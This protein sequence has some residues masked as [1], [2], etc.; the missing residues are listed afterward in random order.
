[1]TPQTEVGYV[2]SSNNY[3]VEL[4][5][6]PSITIGEL[7]ENKDQERGLIHSLSGGFVQ[8]LMLDQGVFLPGQEFKR[9]NSKLSI[10]VGDFLLG[11]SIDP[12]GVPID[13][14]GLIQKGTKVAMMP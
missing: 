6:L 5:G 9:L 7:V 3:L 2:K 8:A 4:N 13:D 10:P 12:L 14:K 11:R 1:M